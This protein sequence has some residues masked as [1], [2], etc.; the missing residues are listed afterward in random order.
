MKKSAVLFLMMSSLLAGCS[1][2]SGNTVTPIDNTNNSNGNSANDLGD[3]ES[4]RV[5]TVCFMDEE[6]DA[7]HYLGLENNTEKAIDK[8]DALEFLYER[9]QT[10]KDNNQ[11]SFVDGEN[12]KE[13][14]IDFSKQK[15][16]L[17]T[18]V[19]NRSAS[20]FAIDDSSVNGDNI[21]VTLRETVEESFNLRYCTIGL[22]YA[23][24]PQNKSFIIN[25]SYKQDENSNIV[26]KPIVYFY[27]EKETD[28]SINYV[29]ED[30][31]LTTYPK[32]NNGWNIHL[33]KDGTF[34]TDE[35]TREYYA[36][37]FDELP[38]YK[39]SFEEGF[40]INKDNAISFLEEKMDYIGFTNRE[41]DE[42]MMYWLPILENN[43]HSLVYF[44]L[45]E[46]RNEECPLIF[47]TEPDTLIRT[48]IHIKK[49][50]GECSIKEQ[51]LKHYDR[52]GFVVTEWGGTEY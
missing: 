47:S 45:T 23:I 36:L 42:F 33:K 31:L 11:I 3:V 9:I 20:F 14:D 8:W 50:D 21:Y 19:H 48:I 17:L 7:A 13:N 44:E 18:T 16:I 38:N 2:N 29:N 34:V 28:L 10:A 5:Q 26:K 24:V 22:V 40:Y 35:N 6:L 1:N 15:V 52:N 43:E 51:Q 49:V 30:K 46:E 39:C 37:Y 4:L 12:L 25:V 32:Y 41:V 27:P